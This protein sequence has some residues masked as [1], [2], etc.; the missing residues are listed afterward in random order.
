MFKQP[1]PAKDLWVGQELL[2]KP[3][4]PA[5]CDNPRREA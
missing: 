1:T 4:L 5:R 3:L 2:N